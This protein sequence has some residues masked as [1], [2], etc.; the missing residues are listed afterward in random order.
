MPRLLPLLCL[1]LTAVL[2]AQD[3]APAPAP[4]AESTAVAA[5]APAPAPAQDA[6][7]APAVPPP[8]PVFEEVTIRNTVAEVVVSAQR[9]SIVRFALLD[10]RPLRLPTPLRQEIERKGRSVPPADQPLAVLDDFQRDPTAYKNRHNWVT[11]LHIAGQTVPDLDGTAP[12]PWRVADRGADAVTF[13][14]SFPERGFAVWISYRMDA[15]RPTVVTTLRVQNISDKA[16]AIAPQVFPFNGIHQDYPSGDVPYLCA[17]IHTGGEAGSLS[18][19]SLPGDLGAAKAIGTGPADYVALKSRFFAALWA[20]VSFGAPAAAAAPA[21]A[22]APAAAAAPVTGGAAGGWSAAVLRG[23]MPWPQAL[24]RVDLPHMALAPGASGEHAWS[25][26]V[27]SVAKEDLALLTTAEQRIKYTDSWYKFFK[28][29]ADLLTWCLTGIASVVQNI[30]VAVIVLTFLLKLLLHR[31]TFKQQESLMKMQK[32]APEMKYLQE[33]FK[34]DRQ[35]LGMETMALYKKHGVNPLGGCLPLLIQMPMFMAL[36][37]AF[38]HSAD[39]RGASFLWIKDLTLPDPIWG[40]DVAWLSWLT[41]NPLALIYIGV[42]VWMSFATKPPPTTDPQQEQMQKMMR[43]LPVIFG[44]IF[45]AMPAGLVLYFTVNA[46]LS[47]IEIK[48]VKKKLGI[49]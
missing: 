46:I 16:Y 12:V 9:A 13:T 25:L 6:A 48:M 18:T 30:G 3:A 45:Y 14:Q 26:T 2:A 41:I 4:A 34:N 11:F 28:L 33:R 10:D 35:K 7:P 40:P 15:K 20:P 32:L 1:L 44:V 47:T 17:A 39:M 21:T 22:E 29:L 37:Q 38:S 31:T 24:L 49:A 23:E 8:P 5:P 42:T 43:W 19:V 27:T 36:Y